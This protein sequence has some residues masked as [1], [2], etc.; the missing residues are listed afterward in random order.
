MYIIYSIYI[1]KPLPILNIPLNIL[2]YTDFYVIMHS[3][4]ASTISMPNLAKARR[5]IKP[6]DEAPGCHQPLAIAACDRGWSSVYTIH[7]P[8]SLHNIYIYIESIKPSEKT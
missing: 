1:L 8:R 4:S 6:G 2:N 3:I 7:N 5:D